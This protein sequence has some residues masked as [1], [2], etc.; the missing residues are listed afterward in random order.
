MANV[1]RGLTIGLS[2]IGQPLAL[3]GQMVPVHTKE[4]LASYQ[5]AMQPRTL[6][7]YRGSWED[8]D[9]S[10]PLGVDANSAIKLE[11]G[12]M[13][14]MVQRKIIFKGSGN[15]NGPIT[16]DTSSGELVKI[17][18]LVVGNQGNK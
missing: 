16:L 12:Y 7:T 10:L 11:L 13:G 14:G 2:V 1:L 5:T 3:V 15:S 17:P 8:M 18:D 6:E 4:D 9:Y